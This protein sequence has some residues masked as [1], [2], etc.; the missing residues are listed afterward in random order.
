MIA[1]EFEAIN[2]NVDTM[3]KSVEVKNEKKLND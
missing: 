1:K 2:I 3:E